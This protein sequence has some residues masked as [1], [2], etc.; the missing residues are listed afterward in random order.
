ME[1]RDSV[2]IL[3]AVEAAD[4]AVGFLNSNFVVHGISFRSEGAEAPG[5]LA[6]QHEAG[7]Y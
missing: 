7:E 2:K 1:Q 6:L 4:D 3:I 5:G